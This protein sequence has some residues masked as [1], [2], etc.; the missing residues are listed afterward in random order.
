M[1]FKYSVKREA[2]L[3]KPKYT[4]KTFSPGGSQPLQSI[5]FFLEIP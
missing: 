1:V 4:G 5:D 2:T 3:K